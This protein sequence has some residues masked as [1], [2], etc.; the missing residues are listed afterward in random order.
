MY[1][2]YEMGILE[3]VENGY[4][5]MSNVENEQMLLDKG[6]LAYYEY[7]LWFSYNRESKVLF[8]DFKKFLAE[9][10]RKDIL[11]RAGITPED[12]KWETLVKLS[13]LKWFPSGFYVQMLEEAKNET[14]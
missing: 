11:E 3:K 10:K 14:R 9:V 7:N 13:K 1:C 6:L 2:T 5:Y 8:A 4:K 12:S